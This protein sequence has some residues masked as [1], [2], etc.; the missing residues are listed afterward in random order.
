MRRFPRAVWLFALI[1]AFATSLPYL[2]AW[3][4]TPEGWQYSGAPVLE[5]LQL[6]YQVYIASMHQ[7][8]E[9]DFYHM[10]FTHEAHTAI[11]LIHL[12]YTALG[13]LAN[14]LGVSMPLMY[15]MARFAL[16]AAMV[17]SLWQLTAYFFRAATS[18]WLALL[19][20]TLGSGWS[21][22]LLLLPDLQIS[23]IEYWLI[24]A[25]NLLG[26]MYVPHFALIIIVQIV[27]VLSFVSW[28]Q[29]IS[30]HTFIVLVV[31]LVLIAILQPYTAPFW[32]GFLGL[33]T[34]YH[35][36]R[37]MIGFRQ[38]LQLS[39]PLMLH[40]GIVLYL[41]M[42]MSADPVWAA[43]VEQTVLL[44]PPPLLFIMGYLPYLIPGLLALHKLRQQWDN[45][46][47]VPLL[48]I[49]LLA[50]LLYMPLPGQRR[51][52]LG[53]H[54]PLA[55]LAAYGWVAYVWPESLKLH[56][57]KPRKE[58][59]ITAL[60]LGGTTLYIALT[61]VA[62][63]VVWSSNLAGATQS[64]ENADI[65][66]AS[67]ELAAY[68]WLEAN[69]TRAALVL[70]VFDFSRGIFNG[71]WL[72]AAI[73]QDVYVGHW[74]FTAFVDEKIAQLE[75]FYNTSTDDTWRLEFLHDAGVRYVWYDAAAQAFGDW[76]P[77]E[78]GYL[79]PVYESDTVQIYEVEL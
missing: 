33:L 38:A 68:T 43:F 44:S 67:D 46:W 22:L 20:A 58:R 35:L 12:T 70:G 47:L 40:S 14:L 50:I 69:T 23:P 48:W 71:G 9:G 55:L 74:A 8:A 15:H 32:V 76:N 60:R 73:G 53:L 26:A 29:Q 19:F 18:R 41:F 66:Y 37:K 11:P 4:S 62:L 6:D 79:L 7:G 49:A 13:V 72:G 30:K 52:A 1:I 28:L 17:L 2:I 54:T 42:V 64:Q 31:A 27:I 39:L 36:N 78:A 25:F 45:R 51:F 77:A 63:L 10:P 3:Q 34:L 65:F 56:T 59:L 24:D 16:T 61:A 75:R 21:W 5:G 57:R